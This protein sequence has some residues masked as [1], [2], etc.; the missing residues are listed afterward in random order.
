MKCRICGNEYNNTIYVAKEMMYGYND[1][2]DYFQCSQCDCLQI[3]DFP[4]N[5]SKYY[6]DNYY[7]YKEPCSQT[8][9][10]KILY[11]IRDGYAISGY[12]IIG[13][14]LYFRRP[15]KKLVFL[16]KPFLPL[17]KNSRILDV[18]CGAGE[19]LNTLFDLG[20]K[21]AHGIDPFN[22]K[23]IEFNNGLSIL[24]KN[25][26]DLKSNWDIIMFNH[27]FEHIFD[28]LETLKKSH[29]LINEAGFCII[30]IPTVTSYAWQHYKTE[31]VQLDA[32]RHFFLHS[33]KS[34]RILADKANF[35]IVDIVYDSTPLQFWG[36]EQYIK[37]IPLRDKRSFCENPE[38]SI[39]T[40]EDISLFSTKTEK[41]NTTNQGDQAIFYLKKK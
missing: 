6:P 7:S 30:R 5:I 21:Q 20:Y 11:K 24:K 29:N 12:G 34:M 41:L 35:E 9:I 31:W 8:I 10:K 28:P 19:L 37:G 32:P 17:R 23:D 33:I 18:G 36:S 22:Q 40:K 16:S 14:L 27:S 3:R 26:H 2:F 25:I 15:N 38:N 4:S 39:F 13:K 1:S